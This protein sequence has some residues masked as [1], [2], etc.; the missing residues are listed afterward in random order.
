MHPSTTDPATHLAES[1]HAA[2]Q[3]HYRPDQLV[4]IMLYGLR[5]GKNVATLREEFDISDAQYNEWL[6]ALSEMSRLALL[7]TAS[8]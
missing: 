4:E 8:E 5:E 7:R 2:E 6:G 1:G 3:R